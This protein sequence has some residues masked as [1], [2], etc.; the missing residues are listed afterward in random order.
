MISISR[1]TV[2]SFLLLLLRGLFLTSID[3]C[4]C[5]VI[6]KCKLRERNSLGNQ[7]V[8]DSEI[9][10]IGNA[11]VYAVHQ[12][13]D[14]CL[15]TRG[16]TAF[17]FYNNKCQRKRCDCRLFALN[18]TGASEEIFKNFT[19]TV[20]NKKLTESFQVGCHKETFLV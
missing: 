13:E 2:Y 11:S 3:F 17:K 12:C 9:K 1:M 4:E 7:G 16:C 18:K 5:V 14:K 15:R 6:G 20:F 10:I 8:A 19:Y